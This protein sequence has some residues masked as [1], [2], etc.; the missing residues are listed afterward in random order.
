MSDNSS[1]ILWILKNHQKS[2]PHPDKFHLESELTDK[3]L[4][5]IFKGLGLPLLYDKVLAF[6][7]QFCLL[8]LQGR[9]FVC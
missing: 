1:L 9:R 6:L 7:G 2:C 3:Q 4:N 5:N 8:K